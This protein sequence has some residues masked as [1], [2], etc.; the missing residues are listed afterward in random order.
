MK[1]IAPVQLTWN[2]VSGGPNLNIISMEL[3][4]PSQVYRV[5]WLRAKARH[6]RWSEEHILIPNEMN[7]TRLFFLNKVKEWAEL[8][9]LAPDKPGHVCFAEE[10][11][12]IWRQLAFRATKA[13]VEA[14]VMCED[15]L[16]N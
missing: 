13:F 2:N 1:K 9:D 8:K 11:V 10:Q 6:E 4:E 15:I 7:W 12:N 14:G 3:T 16:H 5:S